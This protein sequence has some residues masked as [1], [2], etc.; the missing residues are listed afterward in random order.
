M[1][2]GEDWRS[3]WGCLATLLLSRAG[4]CSGQDPRSGASG[5]SP[6]PPEGAAL[7]WFCLCGFF[8]FFLLLTLR[9]IGLPERKNTA[10]G[11]NS[12]WEP[13]RFSN[14]I[15]VKTETTEGHRAVSLPGPQGGSP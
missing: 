10:F 11:L 8:F 15:T 14:V 1:G 12:Y 2:A 3:G 13:S 5:Y 9:N 7:L 4:A 6:R